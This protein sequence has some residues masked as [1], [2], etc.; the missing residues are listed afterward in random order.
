MSFSVAKLHNS[1][2]QA[3][4]RGRP[5]RWGIY[6]IE[7]GTAVIMWHHR[8][9]VLEFFIDWTM[10]DIQ[11]AEAGYWTSSLAPLL[12]CLMHWLP[13]SVRQ[14]VR[15]LSRGLSRG[16][17]SK[18]KW[19][20]NHTSQVAS[21]TCCKQTSVMSVINLRQSQSVDNSCTWR[22]SCLINTWNCSRIQKCTIAS[23]FLS[24]WRYSCFL[25]IANRRTRSVW[26]LITDALVC[27]T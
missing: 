26:S 3:R 9:I 20:S 10:L 11:T 17:I 16:H 1:L 15:C 21:L 25:G 4:P 2:D 12:V 5:Y 24:Q 22:T 14:S 19:P 7:Y 18:A 6:M 27:Y 8:S 13:T 23:S